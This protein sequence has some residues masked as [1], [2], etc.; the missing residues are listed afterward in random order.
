[1]HTGINELA[2]PLLYVFG[3]HDAASAEADCFWAL[4]S[5]LG[6]GLG[7]LLSPEND[8]SRT[9]LGLGMVIVALADSIDEQDKGALSLFCL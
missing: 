1:M 7:D 4:S 5:L 9:V 6:C 8:Q 3:Q 2:A